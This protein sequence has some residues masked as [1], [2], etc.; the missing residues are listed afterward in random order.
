M[1][2][3]QKIDH[4]IEKGDLERT[5]AMFKTKLQALAKAIKSIKPKDQTDPY[6]LFMYNNK[7]IF[8]NQ[9]VSISPTVKQLL[10]T[11]YQDSEYLPRERMYATKHKMGHSKLLNSLKTEWE[12]EQ[13]FP[14]TSRVDSTKKQDKMSEPPSSIPRLNPISPPLKKKP[15]S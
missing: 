3:S 12:V 1:G 10:G 11:R 14:S 8:C 2:V 15:A 6:P 5:S 4:K 13:L 9:G 7:C